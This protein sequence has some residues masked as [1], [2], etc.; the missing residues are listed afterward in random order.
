M[1]LPIETTEITIEREAGYL[2][3]K[4]VF[5]Q[6]IGPDG[7]VIKEEFAPHESLDKA[8]EEMTKVFAPPDG[9]TLKFVI[10]E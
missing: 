9:E 7:K 1:S 2:G 6:I 3:F 10:N 5:K 4:D 8:L